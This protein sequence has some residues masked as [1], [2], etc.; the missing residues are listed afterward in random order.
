[1]KVLFEPTKDGMRTHFG[2]C[3]GWVVALRKSSV[4]SCALALAVG[5]M[6]ALAA[7][8]ARSAFAAITMWEVQEFPRL[9][10]ATQEGARAA[11][12]GDDDAQS[13]ALRLANA[14]LVGAVQGG[15]CEGPPTCPVDALAASRVD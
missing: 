11:H 5:L 15:L 6:P 9:K 10:L 7:A 4:V 2:R 1:M 12:E 14:T 8:Q 3:A 13:L